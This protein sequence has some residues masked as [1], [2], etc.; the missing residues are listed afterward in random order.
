MFDKTPKPKEEVIRTINGAFSFKGEDIYPIAKE[1]YD[2]CKAT[3]KKFNVVLISNRA[4]YNGYWPIDRTRI[5][6]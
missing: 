4:D 6:E 3:E 1:F 5:K 2:W